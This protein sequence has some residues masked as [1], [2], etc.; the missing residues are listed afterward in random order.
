M[1]RRCTLN[2]QIIDCQALLQTT[3]L[4]R[5]QS[6]AAT[7]QPALILATGF[8]GGCLLYQLKP[9]DV[10]NWEVKLNDLATAA[11]V[12]LNTPQQSPWWYQ[13]GLALL[14][15]LTPGPADNPA[16]AAAASGT[17]L[18]PSALQPS[19]VR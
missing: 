5:R 6:G 17:D 1:S 10:K 11:R 8:A 12:L 19:A 18:Q 13:L 3:R 16:P 4:M 2:Q 14:Q 7:W 15:R 9:C